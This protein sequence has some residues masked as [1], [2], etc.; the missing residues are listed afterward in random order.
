MTDMFKK[1][2]L[3][4]IAFFSVLTVLFPIGFTL[5]LPLLF[6]YVLKDNRNIYYLFVPSLLK[7]HE[8]ASKYQAPIGYVTI[9][10]AYVYSYSEDIHK[11]FSERSNDRIVDCQKEDFDFS[12]PVSMVWLFAGTE[13]I[14][15]M[16]KRLPELSF[17]KWGR[18]GCD[19]VDK[20]ESKQRGIKVIQETF[21]YLTEDMY[22]IGNGENDVE[23]FQAV[24]TAIAMGNSNDHVKENAHLVTSALSEDGIYKALKQLGLLVI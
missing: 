6:F 22:A 9:D 5:Y 1:V 10:K 20:G 18:F 11:F 24:G 3:I 2:N 14:D 12:V 15:A 23:M 17:L 7:L 19:I 4:I 21:G 13:V 8:I 16:A